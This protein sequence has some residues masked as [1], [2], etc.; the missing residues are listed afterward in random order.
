MIKNINI[1][2]VRHLWIVG[3]KINRV[4]S[5]VVCSSVTSNPWLGRIDVWFLSFQLAKFFCDIKGPNRALSKRMYKRSH[6]WPRGKL[7]FAVSLFFYTNFA[8]CCSP[9]L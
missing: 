6:A 3:D 1:S 8:I 4:G 7:I 5:F 9:L 2:C